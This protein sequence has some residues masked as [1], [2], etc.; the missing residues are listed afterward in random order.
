VLEL[1]EI[2]L[3]GPAAELAA[4]PRVIASY[5]GSRSAA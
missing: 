5:L 1:G 4:S 3:Q 2:A